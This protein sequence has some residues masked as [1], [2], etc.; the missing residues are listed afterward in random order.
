MKMDEMSEGNIKSHKEEHSSPF[1]KIEFKKILNEIKGR[2]F[3]TIAPSIEVKE[4]GKSQ[5]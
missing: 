1:Y 4:D 2:L 5:S 3:Q